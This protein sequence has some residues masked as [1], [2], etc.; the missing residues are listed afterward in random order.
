MW[1]V[2]TL[3]TEYLQYMYVYAVLYRSSSIGLSH[4]SQGVRINTQVVPK[5]SQG[6]K[7]S[8]YVSNCLFVCM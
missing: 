8:V 1:Y 3:F 5:P 2:H 7:G 4:L 6:A